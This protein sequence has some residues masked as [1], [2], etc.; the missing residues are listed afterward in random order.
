M[1]SSD[2]IARSMLALLL[3]S[4]NKTP[5][6]PF[7]EGLELLNKARSMAKHFSYGSRHD[8][9][10]AL[11]PTG[12][13]FSLKLDINGTRVAAQLTLINSLLRRN[14]GLKAYM[15]K[16][17]PDWALTATEWESLAEIYAVLKTIETV[18]TVAQYET[19]F[20]AAYGLLLKTALLEELRGETF[21]IVQLELVNAGYDMPTKS[22]HQHEFTAVGRMALAR[23]RLEAERR[24]CGNKTEHILGLDVEASDRELLATILDL[25]TKS[26]HSL[27]KPHRK[28]AVA[29]LNESHVAYAERVWA[30]D[31]AARAAAALAKERNAAKATLLALEAATSQAKSAMAALDLG[32]AA[33]AAAAV[34]PPP[35]RAAP[36]SLAFVQQSSWS[37]GD[38]EDD[39]ESSAAAAAAAAAANAKPDDDENSPEN[40]AARR[41]QFEIDATAAAAAWYKAGINWQETFPEAD[42]PPDADLIALLQLNPG[43]AYKRFQKEGAYGWIPSMALCQ[44]GAV[45]AESFCERVFSCAKKVLPEGRTLLSSEELEMV[46]LLRMN[47]EFMKYMRVTHPTVVKEKFGRTV[48]RSE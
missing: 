44:L 46:V 32:G 28:R 20:S 35:K 14:A 11:D 18:S 42:L 21:E 6:N 47:E 40:V 5:V 36:R 12:A 10:D 48:V 29:L 26:M 38:S 41:R 22:K 43:A 34:E 45:N 31:A 3:R 39:G 4:R 16:Y 37:D 33:A 23:A 2:K 30:H 13:K 9:L 15:V 7:P 24:F 17:E 25:R 19:K 1:H 8:E 27:S